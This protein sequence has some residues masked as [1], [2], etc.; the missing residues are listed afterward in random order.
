[1]KIPKVN[2]AIDY[3]KF[4]GG[5]NLE[6]PAMSINPGELL[7]GLNYLADS[8]GSY[9][10]VDGFEIFNGKISPSSC[11]YRYCSVSL[12][13]T[14]N[15]GDTIIG[16]DSGA[17]GVVVI[18]KTTVLCITKVT[19]IFTASEVFTVSGSPKGAMTLLSVLNGEPT[20]L[21]HAE[22]LAATA[23][24]Y[25]ADIV[26]PTG[27][28]AIRG[29][30]ILKGILYCF[31]DNPGGTAGLIYKA[32]DSGWVNIPLYH[33][34]SF[35]TGCS[36]IPDG[37]PISQAISGA[38]AVVKRAVLESGTWEGS[39]IGRLILDEITG[40]FDATNDL[41]HGMVK[42]TAT[43]LATQIT[44]LPGG[45]YETIQYNFYGST[46]TKR[47]YGSDGV[48]RGFELGGDIYVPLSTGM[49]N[50]TPEY[51]FAH[52][53]QLFLSFKGSSQNSGVGTPYSWT[54]ITGAS[55]IG[56]GDDITG[57]SSLPGQ[58]LAICARNQ[59]DQLIGSS[60]SDFV[61]DSISDEVGCIPRTI[62]RLGHTYC[63]DDRGIIRIIPTDSYG[64]FQQN[65]ISRQIQ[66][67][68]D[69]IRKVVV[70][71]V[72][73]KS[74][75]QYRLYGSDGTGVC[76][77][78][79]RTEKGDAFSFTK[80]QYPI[81]I[82]CIV[83]GEDESGKDVI[84]FGAT[85]GKVYQADKGSSFDGEEIEAFLRLSFNNS[86][87][88]AT[89]KTYRKGTIEMTTAGYSVIRVYPDFSYGDPSIRQHVME[90]VEIQGLGGYWDLDNWDEIFYDAS[91]V[92]SPSFPIN[93]DGV[94][95]GLVVYSKSAIDLGH[96]LAGIIIQYIPRRLVR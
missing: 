89:L 49:T 37:A 47:M 12:T 30:G 68:I 46:D 10:R 64:N 17:T 21:G 26:A 5:L 66:S 60:I 61:L 77:T 65:T 75:N 35:D 24:N 79:T 33:E 11:T 58:A 29:V 7:D 34:I 31:I 14:V 96:K 87:S 19:G 72:T 25:R 83:S 39:G 9:S 76:M 62:Q 78:I 48:N 94:N 90:T 57:Y 40:T 55:E 93:G 4:Q 27:S 13:D 81:N 23:E 63:L 82:S 36:L 52:K 86:K 42:A 71:S 85:N 8:K 41:I 88:L 3:T 59:S 6:T 15:I 67:L 54:P 92:S 70:A 20:G 45:R 22:A 16:S 84:F 91:A 53:K 44:I 80:F 28:G 32:T 50:D 73:Y 95:L 69:T 51:V 38:T 1:M 56:L 2:I 43:S 18:N 74:K